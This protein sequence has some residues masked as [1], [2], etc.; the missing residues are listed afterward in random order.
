MQKIQPIHL[1]EQLC[2][3]VY[4]TNKKF[5]HFYQEALRPFDLTYPQYIAMLTLWQYAPLSVKQLGEYLHLDSGTLTPL[6][7]RLESH[8]WITRSR[9]EADERTVIINLTDDATHNKREVFK[10]VNSCFEVLG[11]TEE[12]KDACSQT[13]QTIE[14]KL[15]QYNH[16]V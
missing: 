13:M 3:Q 7:K 11:L 1:D 5:N 8:G 6:L 15:D 4:S 2:F 9:S 10:R 12:E 14:E 16:E